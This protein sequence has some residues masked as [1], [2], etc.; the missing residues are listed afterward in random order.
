MTPEVLEF[1]NLKQYLL[2]KNGN[3]LY[4]VPFRNDWAVLKVYHGSRSMIGY[5]LGTI[6]NFFEGQT[7]FMP[8]ARKKNEEACLALWREAGFRV[9]DTYDDVVVEGLPEDG[10]KLFEFLS[11]V[12]FVDYFGDESVPLEE[13]LAVVSFMKTAILNMS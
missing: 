1:D 10:Y 2:L 13:R 8:K 6:S 9:F 11:E 3:Y 5:I 12:K 4:K 7:S